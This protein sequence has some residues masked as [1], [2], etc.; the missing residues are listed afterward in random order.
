M[1]G[2]VTVELPRGR[3]RGWIE[4]SLAAGDGVA[5]AVLADPP[6]AGGRFRSFVP[7]DTPA[8]RLARLEEGGLVDAEAALAALATELDNL[9]RRGASSL[10]V[11]DDVGRRGDP[12]VAS[13][14]AATS[15]IGDRVVSWA[16]LKP[17]ACELAAR[18]TNYASG[19]PLNAFVSSRSAAELG[20]VDRGTLSEGFGARVAATVMAV[21]VS[22]F[23]AESYLVW[24]QGEPQR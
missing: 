16:D 20:L 7:A 3:A 1:K 15:F 8:E 21:I 12:A 24:D 4:K 6:F 13:S 22:T 5:A 2:L 11:E 23:D 10:V 17:G 19:Y 14:E 18:V 9:K